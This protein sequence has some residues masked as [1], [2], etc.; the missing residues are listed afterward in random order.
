LHNL[1]DSRTTPIPGEF[2]F[3]LWHPPYE[4][5]MNY[6]RG[7]HD[8]SRADDHDA[9]LVRYRAAFEKYWTQNFAPGG[10]IAVLMGD[11][12]RGGRYL[13]LCAQ[14]ALLAPQHVRRAGDDRDR[15]R[16]AG[17]LQKTPVGTARREPGHGAP[18]ARRE[19][20]GAAA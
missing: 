17:G 20:A 2:D 9:W 18:R 11:A 12:R 7:E 5:L 19:R 8:L 4:A 16:G 13:P 15:A 1:F 14:T 6:Q 3:V 10:R